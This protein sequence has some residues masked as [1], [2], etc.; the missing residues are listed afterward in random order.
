[1]AIVAALA[2]MPRFQPPPPRDGSIW[3][4]LGLPTDVRLLQR[5]IEKGMNHAL[6]ERFARISHLA[7]TQIL[8]SLNLSERTLARRRESGRLQRE[9]SDR[10]VS[11]LTIYDAA[12]QLFGGNAEAASRW[13]NSAERAL[14]GQTPVE[15]LR[16]ELG[17]REVLALIH[18]LEHG[19]FM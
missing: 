17:T 1:M 4:L 18:R 7:P 3:S 10:L 14:G 5:E 13:L 6:I 12:L 8:R 2:E 16:T 11:L 9:E 15:Y 19:V